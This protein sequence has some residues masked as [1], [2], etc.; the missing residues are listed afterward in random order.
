[1]ICYNP[2]IS[3]SCQYNRLNQQ[4]KLSTIKQNVHMKEVI[5]HLTST[6]NSPMHR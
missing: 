3:N 1:M 2:P 6:Q 4:N 5:L